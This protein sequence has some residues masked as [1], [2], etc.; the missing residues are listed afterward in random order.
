MGMRITVKFYLKQPKSDSTVVYAVAHYMGKRYRIFTGE[1]VLTEFWNQ[2]TEKLRYSK[3]N[4]DADISNSRIDQYRELIIKALN[5]FSSN[6]YP[7]Q[8]E[9]VKHAFEKLKLQ[10]SE[11]SD[12][13]SL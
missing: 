13:L 10:G 12:F 9:E 3:A 6:M 1:K 5:T 7:P 2:D 8:A 4:P 11:K